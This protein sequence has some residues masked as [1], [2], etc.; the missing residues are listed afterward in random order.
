MEGKGQLIRLTY[1]L[2]SMPR[3]ST[4][5]SFPL[6]VPRRL[7]FDALLAS[8][9]LNH[10]NTVGNVFG[11]AKKAGAKSSTGSGS[12]AVPVLDT[13]DSVTRRDETHLGSL[14]TDPLPEVKV[15]KTNLVEIKGALDDI[16]KKV[17][18][19]TAPKLIPADGST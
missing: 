15:N 3:H 2:I 10:D 13:S 19:S 9:P 14:D 1:M 6:F 8:H 16:V 11:M 12:T 5:H 17:P 18:L 4:C 7:T